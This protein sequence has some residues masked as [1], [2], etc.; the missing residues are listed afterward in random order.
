MSGFQH[1]GIIKNTQIDRQEFLNM[2]ATTPF[3][4]NPYYE[5]VFHAMKLI[6]DELR[7]QISS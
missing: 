1:A 2:Q 5:H 3:H 7:Q 6:K 4:K